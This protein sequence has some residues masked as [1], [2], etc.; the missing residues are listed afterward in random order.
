MV[1][2]LEMIRVKSSVIKAIDY[3]GTNV[4]VH[5]HSDKKYQYYSVPE[6]IFENLLN[7]KS[8]GEFWNLRIKPKY[9]CRELR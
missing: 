9:Q 8:K 6:N 2:L 5:L 3:D 1:I 7:A 4:E